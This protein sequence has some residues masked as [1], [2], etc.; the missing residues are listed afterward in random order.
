TF[1]RHTRIAGQAFA[2]AVSQPEALSYRD[3]LAFYQVVASE[4]RDRRAEER[5]DLGDHVELEMAIRQVVSDAVAAAG[6]IDIYKAAG[7]EKPD[8]SIIDDEFTKRFSTNPHPN[9]QI[10]L[11]RRL[12]ATEVRSTARRNIV[13]GRRFSEML[14]RAM[15]AYNNRT[16]TAAEVVQELVALAKSIKEE[17]DRGTKLGLNADELAFYDAVYQN[18]SAIVE[19]GDDI[20]KAIA[21][22]LVTLVRRNATVDWDKKEQVR[23]NM[24]RL[25]KRLLIKHHYPPDQQESAIVLVMEQAEAL[26]G[27]IAA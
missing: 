19:L 10:E 18:E 7:L 9:L 20:L 8:L 22:E 3:D 16:L 17:K 14:E 11:L 6:V 4:L 13:A 21:Q 1:L 26:A 24:R 27:E 2:L 23:A 25:I 15:T 5:G 12:L